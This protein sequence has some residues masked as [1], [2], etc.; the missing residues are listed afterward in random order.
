MAAAAEV[1]IS[2]D[3]IVQGHVCVGY[4]CLNG[5]DFA[6]DTLRLKEN[7]VRIRFH[8]TTV[9]DVLGQSWNISANDKSNGGDAYMSFELKSLVAD[10]PQLSDG[11][12]PLYDCTDL[13]Y[14]FANNSTF[15]IV[16]VIPEGEPATDGNCVPLPDEFTVKTILLL[17]TDNVVTAEV[18]EDGVAI[19]Y[20]SDA[21][22]GAVSVGR[23]TLT[24]QVS[25]VADGVTATD[26]LTTRILSDYVPFAD[27]VAL[28]AQLN[29]QL[30]TLDGQ[31]DDVE[32]TIVL[33]GTNECVAESDAC[34]ANATCSD[35]PLSFSCACN[36]GYSGD[37]RSCADVDE[38]AGETDNCDA[39]AT[40]SNSAG[41]FSCAC[42]AGYS[43]DGRTC[44]DVDADN[45]GIEDSTDNCPTA[46]NPE[47]VDT[48]QDSA[49]DACDADDDG[50]GLLDTFEC[51]E[52]GVCV[53][54]DKDNIVDSLDD[55]DDG[56]TVPTK[57]ECPDPAAGCPDTDGDGL[58]DHHDADDDADTVNTVLEV[59]PFGRFTSAS[60][61]LIGRAAYRAV[62]PA[63]FEDTDGDGVPNFLD[64]DDDGDGIPTLA[65][66]AEELLEDLDGDGTPNYLDLDSD[67]DTLPDSVE[68]GGDT[69][70]DGT[71]DFAD[72]DA[73]G[74]GV[75]DEEE[76]G[77]DTDGDGVPDFKEPGVEATTP[78]GSEGED[79]SGTTPVS[80]S[81]C[82]V[83]GQLSKKGSGTWPASL[84]GLGVAL[85]ALRR[86]RR[87]TGA[88]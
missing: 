83:S 54:T 52:P 16:G 27:K 73:D 71:P 58:P 74:D 7:N 55:D 85:V 66:A 62:V 82:A 20:E 81:G 25:N 70:G 15:P 13:E 3:Q 18:V 10:F 77:G 37:G 63:Q 22:D 28:V 56:D 67:G 5:E 76:G 65:E 57:T 43:G 2:D 17:T 60:G 51:T 47:Q 4:D 14:Y 30:D 61:A 29:G 9:G 72:L 26:A 49:G 38:C 42:N 32:A 69:D 11:T 12:A 31:L 53:D 45:D 78:A 19:G 88:G 33:L 41:S 64:N 79:A 35:T 21:V 50:D 8:D 87:R 75:S 48:D 34:D 39:N 40:C 6:G 80:S 84:L 36:A 23:A 59:D 44:V 1:A 68:G 24:R 86:R 46:A